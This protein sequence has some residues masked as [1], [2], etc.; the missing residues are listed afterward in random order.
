MACQVFVAIRLIKR[1]ILG[2]SRRLFKLASANKTASVERGPLFDVS[3]GKPGEMVKPWPL[4]RGT[5]IRWRIIFM[6]GHSALIHLTQQIQ[7]LAVTFTNGDGHVTPLCVRSD[8]MNDD[9]TKSD[10]RPIL[11]RPLQ[12]DRTWAEMRQR[13]GDGAMVFGVWGLY[14]MLWSIWR[15]FHAFFTGKL[16]STDFTEISDTEGYLFSAVIIGGIVWLVYQRWI[17]AGLLGLLIG[18]CAMMVMVCYVLTTDSL[19][20]WVKPVVLLVAVGIAF[21][22]GLLAILFA[23]IKYRRERAGVTSSTDDLP[24][25]NES[26]G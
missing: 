9:K 12:R 7:Y 2:L 19:A 25:S 6:L 3:T 22:A 8:P 11:T 20:E 18:I 10:A 17:A 13:Y 16:F 5:N 1:T 21:A 24:P 15:F 4:A 26:I 14:L 23:S